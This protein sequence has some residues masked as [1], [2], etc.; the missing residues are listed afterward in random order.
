MTDLFGEDIR[1]DAV[2]KSESER[3]LLTRRW[4][5]GGPVALCIGCNP[6]TADARQEDATTHTLNRWFRAH[7]YAGYDI[8]N[9]YPFC[10]SSPAECRRIADWEKNGPDYAARDAMWFN[11][12][13][14]VKF[15][16]MADRVFACWGNIAWDGDW[17]EHVVEQIQTGTEPWLDLWCFGTTKS[18]APKHPM[19]RGKHRITED[20]PMKLW[21][22]T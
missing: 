18:G 20:T 10:T 8:M 22:T 5:S 14:L 13:E 4:H 11:I 9:L 16:K 1:R 21:R 19:A 3:I 6:S 12:G 7:G 17:T 2:F 15:A